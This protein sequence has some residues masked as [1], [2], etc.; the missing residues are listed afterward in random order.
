[1]NLMAFQIGK[2][3]EARD[4]DTLK[5]IRADLCIECGCCAYVCPAKRDMVTANKLAKR[6]MADEARK[7]A[8]K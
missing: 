1:M 4:L 3:Y 2:A 8:N 5:K 7:E 6:Y